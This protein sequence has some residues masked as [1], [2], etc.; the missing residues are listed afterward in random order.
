MSALAA[1]WTSSSWTTSSTASRSPCRKLLL[2]LH[3]GRNMR[4]IPLMVAATLLAGCGGVTSPGGGGH[5]VGDV[6]VGNISAGAS[7]LGGG[8][9]HIFRAR[10]LD[11]DSLAGTNP[12]QHPR[13]P[14]G[15]LRALPGR[16]LLHDARSTG[17]VGAGGR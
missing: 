2:I 8:I 5:P 3:G 7:F 12:A 6:S 10:R 9:F 14:G 15:L 4:R 11:A 17:R 13:T 1:R 16:V